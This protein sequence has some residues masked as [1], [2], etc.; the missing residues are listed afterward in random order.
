[1]RH[2]AI[3]YFN[4]RWNCAESVVLAF[5]E[6][7]KDDRL[8]SSQATAFGG[9]GGRS[10]SLCGALS[11]A[12]IVLGVLHGRSSP[13]EKELYNHV[14]AQAGKL[15]DE[16]KSEFGDIN[17][18]ALTGYLPVRTKSDLVKFS[19]DKDRHKKCCRYVKAASEIL[20]RLL[21]EDGILQKEGCN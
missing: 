16:F 5:K 9:G 20:F 17:C 4:E 1:M 10:G 13:Q 2:N 11:G 7:T 6:L 18:T 19:R 21:E 3:K 15:M 14:Q 12:L 8:F